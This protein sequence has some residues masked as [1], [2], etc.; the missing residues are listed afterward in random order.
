M[1]VPDDGEG[2]KY[3]QNLSFVITEHLKLVLGQKI[4]L[5]HLGGHQTWVGS[6]LFAPFLAQNLLSFYFPWNEMNYSCWNRKLMTPNSK[7]K[8]KTCSQFSFAKR[9]RG[10]AQKLAEVESF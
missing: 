6:W 3:T 1:A 7:Q 5:W 8:I 9:I 2:S 10:L 4:F